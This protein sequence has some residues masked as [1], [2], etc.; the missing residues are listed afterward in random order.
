[1]DLGPSSIFPFPAGMMLKFISRGRRRDIAE[2]L[3]P[4]PSVLAHQAPPAPGFYRARWPDFYR[5]FPTLFV[6]GSV[7]QFS[8]E[9]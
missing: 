3:L 1:M 7:A 2:V 6:E 4:G 8:L 5:G 9:P